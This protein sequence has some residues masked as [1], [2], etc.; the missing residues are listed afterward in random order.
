MMRLLRRLMFAVLVTVLFPLS[1]SAKSG[2][3]DKVYAFGYATCL[4]DSAVYLCAVQMLDGAT[5]DKRTGFLN[6]REDYSRQ[7]EEALKATYGKDF[8]CALVFSTKKGK[9][10]K[11]YLAIRKRLRKD[12]GM[13]VNELPV[14]DFRFSPVAVPEN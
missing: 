3:A 7:M 1:A 14:A 6:Y 12:K 5:I 13:L 9:A 10:E 8:T 4:G 2:A 11:K